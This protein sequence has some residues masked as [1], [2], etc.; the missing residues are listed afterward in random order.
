MKSYGDKLRNPEWQK[1][2]LL[3]LKRDKFKCQ[4]CGDT[5]SELHVHH[6]TYEFGKDPWEYPATNFITYCKICHMI[7][8]FF[9]KEGRELVFTYGNDQIRIAVETKS[10]DLAF[11]FY[12][13]ETHVEHGATV[14]EKICKNIIA[15]IRKN[16]RKK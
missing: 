7:A 1:K 4:S 12:I 8:E 15:S 6:K 3:I 5:K 2:R 14:N 13:E 9:R 16:Q 11:L 10:R